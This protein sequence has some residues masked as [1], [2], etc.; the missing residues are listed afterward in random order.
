LDNAHLQ[1]LYR[2]A[3]CKSLTPLNLK[4][5]RL[6]TADNDFFDIDWYGKGDKPL[7]ILLHG[8]TGS[9]QS[10][11][12]S[13]LQLILE[14][15]GIRSVAL[16]FRGCSGEPNK[17]ARGYHSGDTE[18]I[19]FLYQSLRQHEPD[20]PMA[21]V[22]FSLGGNVLLKWLGEQGHNIS[23]AAAVAVSVPLLL[24]KCATKLDHGFSK[25]YRY[26][27]IQELKHFIRDKLHYLQE[28]GAHQEV[29]KILELGDLST[30]KSFWQYDD[31]VVARLH[32]FENVQQ[33]YQLSSSK[34]YLD[35]IKIPTLLIQSIDD[36]FMTRSVIPAE[37]ELSLSVSLEVTKS[38]GHVGFISGNIPFKPEYWLE[39]RIP[40]FLRQYGIG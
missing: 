39:Q 26:H 27:L 38:G 11:Y 31:K 28:I 5:E 4:R 40:E 33:Y 35:K 13:G 20:V 10:V 17:L 23:L 15:Q 30:I 16:N 7:V 3:C 29:S 14:Q 36:P 12:I 18:D 37:E 8:L 9:S 34:Q 19:D 21:M 2:A 32:A 22:G 1:T 25:L 6:Y 24:D